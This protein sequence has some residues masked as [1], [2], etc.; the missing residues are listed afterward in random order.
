MTG[1][2]FEIEEGRPAGD[3]FFKRNKKLLMIAGA[4]LVVVVVVLAI[5]LPLTLKSKP[6]KSDNSTSV[7]TSPTTTRL[8][9][10]TLSSVQVIEKPDSRADCVPW[11]KSWSA[12]RVEEECKKNAK[13]KYQPVP[14]NADIP[15]CFYDMSKMKIKLLGQNTSPN[16]YR[17]QLDQN[18]PASLV[19]LDVQELEESVVRFKV[20]F[21]DG[22]T[23]VYYSEPG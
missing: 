8:T 4:G 5:V 7:Q 16:S 15:A 6:D 23:L 12:N 3:S 20:G 9:T 14:G 13:C 19:N 2:V 22:Q 18:D 11:A 17:L 21:F 10:A 1:R